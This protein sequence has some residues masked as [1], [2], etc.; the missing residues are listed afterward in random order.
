[1]KSNPTARWKIR[2]SFMLVWAGALHS[3]QFVLNWSTWNTTRGCRV[4]PPRQGNPAQATGILLERWQPPMLLVRKRY[5]MVSVSAHHCFLH[6]SQC[7]SLRFW[8]PPL[9]AS[10]L[11]PL[12]KAE[13]KQIKYWHTDLSLPRRGEKMLWLA[14]VPYHLVGFNKEVRQQSPSQGKYR[15][16]AK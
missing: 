11:V 13:E 14:Y 2:T 3:G 4:S 15:A 5:W 16:D 1:M 6:K 8:Y 10:L 7:D 9:L 12:P